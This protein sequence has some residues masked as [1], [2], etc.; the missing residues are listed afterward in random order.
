MIDATPVAAWLIQAAPS[1]AVAAAFAA[2]YVVFLE[3]VYSDARRRLARYARRRRAL[4]RVESWY[5]G[6]KLVPVS[7]AAARSTLAA[8]RRSLER[9]GI[10]RPGGPRRAS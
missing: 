9:A 10:L 3:R 5:P 6:E 4:E 7:L 8:E 2:A 1:L